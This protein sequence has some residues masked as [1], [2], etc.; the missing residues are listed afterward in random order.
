MGDMADYY[1]D[2]TC[3]FDVWD[4]TQAP[5]YDFWSQ[6]DRSLIALTSMKESHIRNCLRMIH[7]RDNWR[8]GWITPFAEELERRKT[9]KK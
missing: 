7:R 1:D 4:T 5:D 3:D 9:K 2:R 6:K 8:R